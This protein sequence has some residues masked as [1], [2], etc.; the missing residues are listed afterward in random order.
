MFS[1]QF[2]GMGYSKDKSSFSSSGTGNE[3]LDDGEAKETIML[4]QRM[5]L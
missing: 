1:D 3:D 2:T 4:S 5:K